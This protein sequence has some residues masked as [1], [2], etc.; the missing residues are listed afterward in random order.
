[1]DILSPFQI[2]LS[3]LVSFEPE[4][5]GII[6]LSLGVSLTA[7]GISLVIGLPL[8][9]L[10]AAYRFPGRGAIIVISN[11]FLGMPPV[12]VGLVI[13]LLVSRA[14]PFGFLGILYTP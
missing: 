14:G 1:M 9:A 3:L 11:T 8:G 2:A 4:L 10:L 6:G 5:M 12:V 7:V 13:Y